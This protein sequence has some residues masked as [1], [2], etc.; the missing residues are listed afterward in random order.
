MLFGGAGVFLAPFKEITMKSVADINFISKRAEKNDFVYYDFKQFQLEGFPWYEK[1]LKL[2][3]MP[4]KLLERF[5][6]N[7][8]EIAKSTAGGL[9]RFKTNTEKMALYAKYTFKREHECMS[10]SVDAGFDLYL[11]KDGEY[12]FA[13]NFRPNLGDDFL[14]MEKLIANTGEAREYILYFPLFSWVEE[15]KIGIEKNSVIE[16]IE[17]TERKKLLFYGSSVTHGGAACRPGLTYPAILSRKLNCEMINLGY[18]G[19]CRGEEF[20]AKEIAKLEFNAFVME[21]DHNEA[22]AFELNKKHERFFK[23]IRSSHKDIPIILMSR[24]DFSHSVNQKTEEFK[25]VVFNTYSNAVESGDKNVYFVDGRKIFP[26][27]TRSDFT[28]DKVH[29]N[30]MGF[31]LMADNLHAILKNIL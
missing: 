23:I 10:Q 22:K 7:M 9:I 26:N 20:L 25:K 19:N 4:E 11:V 31:Y 27:K 18:A 12:E 24:P 8:Q 13:A 15:L 6:D 30:D 28:S 29:P 2:Y 3:R 21:Y 14:D 5:N 16:N 17:T 1:D